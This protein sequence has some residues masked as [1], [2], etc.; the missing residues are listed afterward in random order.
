[1]ADEKQKGQ[2]DCATARDFEAKPLTAS[3]AHL[4]RLSGQAEMN[5]IDQAR[6]NSSDG[7]LRHYQKTNQGGRKLPVDWEEQNQSIELYDGGVSIS[8][9]SPLKEANLTAI[10]KL[11]QNGK[12]YTVYS[13]EA[14]QA[15][16]KL[17]PISQALTQGD[18]Q[19]SVKLN[20]QITNVPEVSHGVSPE[21]LLG[22]TSAV[23]D[24]GAEAV[25]PIEE[26]LTKPNAINNDLRKLPGAAMNVLGH[27]A[28]NS[29]QFNK[30]VA[31]FAGR[32]LDTI[33]K[34]MTLEQ[35]AAVSGT[36]MPLFFLEGDSKPLDRETVY[37]MQLGQM[38]AEHLRSIGIERRVLKMPQIPEELR[39]MPLTK[40]DT[41]L[42]DA[43]T[44]Q[45]R[46]IRIAEPGT[47]LERHL[48][49]MEAEASVFNTDVAEQDIIL[50]RPEPNKIAVLEEFLH[51]TQRIIDALKD[52]ERVILELH[53]KDF[54]IRHRKILGL[55]DNDVEM[56][57]VLKGKELERAEMHGH[58]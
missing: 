36:L 1:M 58:R 32:A 51:G 5:Q 26:H 35:R 2:G 54:M 47:D 37:Q 29:E 42:L 17:D 10:A 25:R 33:D 18:Y 49:S 46:D 19:E 41:K 23:M 20:V 40:A 55:S 39:D 45:N 15:T 4:A 22:F 16:T 8:R 14:S 30:D 6:T 3:D 28:Q 13:K 34:P 56:L 27:F 57:E 38:P 48:N 11:N 52:K 7:S 24:A 53:V 31:T 9:S 44:K 50:L 43:V 21:E 12:P